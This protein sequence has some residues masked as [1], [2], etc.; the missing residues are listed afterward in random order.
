MT[1]NA[2][3]QETSWRRDAPTDIVRPSQAECRDVSTR[4]SGGCLT[5]NDA[6]NLVSV[7]PRLH[8]AETYRP[9]RQRRDLKLRANATLAN[10]IS[11]LWSAIRAAC[12]VVLPATAF[13]RST[14]LNES[15]ACSK[16]CNCET[17]CW[18]RERERRRCR[19]ILW[20]GDL[21]RTDSCT[22]RRIVSEVSPEKKSSVPMS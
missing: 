1:R 3:L 12:R 2:R 9:A 19:C 22:H 7:C 13:V 21:C 16:R 18:E 4:E 8:S 14:S 6:L 15:T 5:S 17:A 10:I 20:F 11:P